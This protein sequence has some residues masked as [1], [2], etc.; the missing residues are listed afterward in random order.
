VSVNRFY[1]ARRFVLGCVLILLVWALA[2]KLVGFASLVVDSTRESHATIEG[3]KATP[4]AREIEIRLIQR[5]A[6]GLVGRPR[7]DL[8]CEPRTGAWTFVCSFLPTPGASSERVQFGVVVDH[9]HEIYEMSRL[10]PA[11][12][13]LPSPEKILIVR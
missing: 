12:T 13:A 11:G 10:G 1:S 2:G 3:L 6:F 7:A 4:P 9:D 8:Q 5:N